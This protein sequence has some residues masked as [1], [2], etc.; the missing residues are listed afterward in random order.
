MLWWLWM[1]LGL[2]LLIL[3]L[4][5]ASGFFL[6]FC[7][8]SAILVGGATAAF[9][10]LPAS[11]QWVAFTAVSFLSILAFRER[12]IR[13]FPENAD[14]Y[15]SDPVGHVAVAKSPMG[16]NERGTVEYHGAAWSARN[17]GVQ[18]IAVGDR[19]RI[20]RLEGLLLEVNLE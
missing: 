4:G 5:V 3:E 13:R 18:P 15:P 11:F 10:G 1:L 20:S 14:A 6:L 2:A 7:G 17:V 8:F 19:C 16:A 12:L 9:G